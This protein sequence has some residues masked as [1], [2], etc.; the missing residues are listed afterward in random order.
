[1][2]PMLAKTWTETIDPTGWWMSEKLDGVRAIW[3][4][5]KFISRNGKEFY[6]PEWFKK[7]MPSIKLDGEL[8]LGRG[9]F[10]ELVSIVKKTTPDER[11]ENVLYIVFDAPDRIAAAEKS[12][13]YSSCGRIIFSE[14]CKNIDYF[15]KKLERVLKAGG[16]GI[17]LR[18]QDSPYDEGRS[19]F[20]LKVKAWHDAEATVVEHVAG[21]GRHKGRL[22]ALLVENEAGR[23]KLGTGL[24]DKERD[25]PPAIGSVVTYKYQELT[26]AG[27]PRFPVY[28][29]ERPKE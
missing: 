13:L 2:K 29:R 24:T 9:K 4:G 28:M 25:N 21:K 26:K 19:D 14:L 20:L 16:E 23:F 18:K 8:W 6:A 12:L 17:M 27:I 7:E 11:W 22:G 5:E 1:M 10:Q 15:N 3:T